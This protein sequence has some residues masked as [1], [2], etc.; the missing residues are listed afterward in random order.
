MKMKKAWSEKYDALKSSNR[1][2]VERLRN[3]I[4][5]RDIHNLFFTV[6]KF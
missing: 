4:G 1:K 3:D 6:I 2:K 5:L